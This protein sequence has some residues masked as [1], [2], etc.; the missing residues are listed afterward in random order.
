MSANLSKYWIFIL[1][2]LG[3]VSC[4]EADTERDV[5]QEQIKYLPLR[6]DLQ[7]GVPAETPTAE[8]RMLVGE[9]TGSKVYYHWNER[10]SIGSFLLNVPTK[11]GNHCVMADRHAENHNRARFSFEALVPEGTQV[12]DLHAFVYYPYNPSLVQVVEGK[13]GADYLTSGITYRIPYVQ[14]QLPEESGPENC[15]EVMSRYGIAYDLLPCNGTSGDFEM[16]HQTAYFRFKV[17]GGEGEGDYYNQDRYRLKR[18]TV[19]AGKRVESIDSEGVLRYEMVEQ[20]HISG[21]FTLKL[22]YN[23]STFDGSE[24]LVPVS[25]GGTSYVAT[26]LK[27]AQ[28]LREPCWV[29]MAL[30]PDELGD[31]AENAER[32]LQVVMEVEVYDEVGDVEQ[33]VSC[34]RYISLAGKSL[35]AGGLYDIPLEFAAPLDTYTLLD[36]EESANTYII[37]AGGNYIFSATKPGNGVV[38]YNT[39]W[40]DLASEGVYPNLIEEGKNYK[41]DWLWASGSIFEKHEVDEVMSTCFF[42]PLDNTIN[43]TINKAFHASELKGNLVLALYETDSRGEFKEIVWTWLLWLSQP[44]VVHFHFANT[45]PSLD[46]N[47]SEWHVMDR[48]LGAE[49]PG[50]GPR[51]VGLYYQMGRKDPFVGPKDLGDANPSYKKNKGVSFASSFTSQWEL[52]RLDTKCNTAV[53]GSNVAS[54]QDNKTQSPTQLPG[55]FPMW[56]MNRDEAQLS[57]SARIYAWVHSNSQ[58]AHQTKTLFDPCPPGYKLPTTREWDNLKSSTLEY[59]NPVA[60]GNGTLGYAFYKADTGGWEYPITKNLNAATVNAQNEVEARVAAG[61]YYEV[62]Y[63]LGGKTMGRRYTLTKGSLHGMAQLYFPVTGALSEGG[64]FQ[65]LSTNITLWSSGRIEGNEG[66]DAQ[67]FYCYWFGVKSR[68]DY[69]NIYHNEWD[70]YAFYTE[71]LFTNPFGAESAGLT[72]P[73]LSY[74]GGSV[75]DKSTTSNYAA[76]IRCI[77]TYN[78]TY[79]Q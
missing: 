55:H 12:E 63:D 34:T 40:E 27:H 15:T 19:Q 75:S 50:F 57:S 56:L 24:E 17:V 11:E 32:Y 1:V 44:D 78:S 64:D 9:I 72:N 66:E 16:H 59:S 65:R 73:N 5:D 20:P 39:S 54:W 14:T 21:T 69:A 47:N 53:F 76:P 62:D 58:T 74:S 28:S 30:S 41:V 33:M 29:F 71:S 31:V 46:L 43:L 10:D 6:V 42:D 79:E 45:R 26:E 4:M 60:T 70:I 37:P 23:E 61:D 67:K 48:N 35:K 49:E 52:N 2:L 3:A 22:D 8:T 77:R 25:H 13:T 7:T 36:T 18:V 51:S 38:P 68:G